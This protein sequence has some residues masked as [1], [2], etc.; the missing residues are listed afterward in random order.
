[1]L[2]Y[3][4]NK[5]NVNISTSKYMNFL[6]K[7]NYEKYSILNIKS[8]LVLLFTTYIFITFFYSHVFLQYLNNVTKNLLPNEP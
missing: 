1:M 5:S 8:H 6:K 4:H 2:E 7:K 3:L